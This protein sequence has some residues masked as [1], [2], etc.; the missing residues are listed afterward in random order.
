MGKKN[1]KKWNITEGLEVDLGPWVIEFG[2]AKPGWL[3]SFPHT[4]AYVVCVHVCICMCVCVCKVIMSDAP[5]WELPV[6]IIDNNTLAIS[7]SRCP[8]SLL[9]HCLLYNAVIKHTHTHKHTCADK[10]LVAL[11]RNKVCL[12]PAVWPS[13][14]LVF[15]TNRALY[16][17]HI[18]PLWLAT[19]F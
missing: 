16:C 19:C 7:I 4:D 3:T 9:N 5:Y 15:L 11:L 14:L 10:D 17:T 6:L 13:H 1:I 12:H 18:R 2:P 8:V